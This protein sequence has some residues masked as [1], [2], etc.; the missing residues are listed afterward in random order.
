MLLLVLQILAPR[1]PVARATTWG[2]RPFLAL[3]AGFLFKDAVTQLGV[4]YGDNISD[5][6]ESLLPPPYVGEECEEWVLFVSFTD[7]LGMPYQKWCRIY[8][9]SA[10][11]QGVVM[12]LIEKLDASHWTAVD[13]RGR[14]QAVNVRDRNR[15]L[16]TPKANVNY[17]DVP[18]F[19]QAQ[20]VSFEQKS[21]AL[22][23]RR[24]GRTPPAQ[25]ANGRAA[26]PPRT[27][28]KA[29]LW[30]LEMVGWL[31]ALLTTWSGGLGFAALVLLSW[32]L[33]R[34]LGLWELLTAALYTAHQAY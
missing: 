29:L 33:G 25:A 19:S 24:A 13:P 6:I 9:Q 16:S 15:V 22:V 30:A 32:R 12:L 27:R 3:V 14:V 8:Y 1:V 5:P 31:A 21:A 4:E 20:L 7:H 28:R 11:Q 23:A 18:G 10:P 2:L 34:Y 17:T 26:R